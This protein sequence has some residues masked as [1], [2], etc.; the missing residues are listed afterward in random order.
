MKQPFKQ[1]PIAAYFECNG[2]IWIKKTSRTAIGVWPAILPRWA[3]FG[4]SEI[5]D[6]S[7][8]ALQAIKRE[9]V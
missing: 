1:L 6:T 2:N 3:Y 4:Q 9:S 7:E 8:R 5:C